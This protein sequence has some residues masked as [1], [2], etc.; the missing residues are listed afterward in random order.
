[1]AGDIPIYEIDPDD[2][3]ARAALER[4]IAGRADATPFHRPAW[5]GAVARGTGQQAI[6]LVAGDMAGTPAGILPLNL[7]HSPLFGRALVSSGFAVDGGILADDPAVAAAL[8]DAAVRLAAR[9][10]CPT[11]ELRGGPSP[12]PGWH[13]SAKAYLGFV[14]PLAADDQAEL[15]AIPRK[16]RAEVRK[17]LANDLDIRFGRDAAFRDPFY[18]LYCR[19]VH[20]LGTPVFPRAMFDEVL[21]AF[22]EDAEIVLVSGQ[23]QP[24][25]AVL[26]LY[27]GDRI[28][29]YWQGADRD[30][31]LA[32]ANEVAYFALMRR[33][34]ERGCAQFD[35]GRSKV[36]TGTAAYKKN[37]GFEGV[38]LAYHIHAAPGHE[39]R[40]INPLSPQYRRKV[41]LWKAL[42]PA[43]AD[44]LGPLIARGLG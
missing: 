43:I 11:V 25:S 31:R 40:D 18:A 3:R 29:P 5:I 34:R 14:R 16:H 23:G 32:R 13:T 41:A 27:H 36:G 10:V 8:A 37:W 33:G 6:M 38:P 17:G 35:F 4:W 20:N 2:P 12:G 24:L 9:R 44:R 28:M 39:A 7:I 42:P 1:M 26:A 30:A 22:G 21:D 19:S 15:E